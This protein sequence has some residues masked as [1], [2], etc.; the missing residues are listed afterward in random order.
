[1]INV[2]NKMLLAFGIIIVISV[3]SFCISFWGYSSIL[4]A[5]NHIDSNK[6]LEDSINSIKS[7]VFEEQQILA[8][9]I[10][11]HESSKKNFDDLYNSVNT[12]IDKL[13]SGNKKGE[14]VKRLEGKDVKE[15]NTLKEINIKYHELFVNQILTEIE[16]DNKR[17]L[18]TLFTEE[19]K[20]FANVLELEQKLFDTI[21]N[22]VDSGLADC[23]KN[24]QSLKV[25]NAGQVAG[26]QKLN[27]YLEEYRDAY[28]K[29]ENSG[30]DQSSETYYKTLA[31]LLENLGNSL[32]KISAQGNNINSSMTA[33]KAVL[34][35]LRLEDI[36][37]NLLIRANVSKLIFATQSKYYY[38]ADAM[39]AKDEAFDKY[40]NEVET[41]NK[42]I[43]TLS[44]SLYGDEIK[45]IDNIKAAN[46]DMDKSFDPIL[47]EVRRINSNPLI[48]QY[49]NSVELMKQYD[50]STK[51]LEG[52]F[53][54]YL[55]NDVKSSEKIREG[56]IISLVIVTLI[57]LVL[58]MVL[59]LVLSNNILNPIRAMTHLLNKA[60][61]GD[62]TV[63][64][65]LNRNDEI[66]ELGEKVNCILDGQ[67]KMVGQVMSTTKDIS[68]LKQKLSEVFNQSRENI[69]K[70]S[71]GI[72]N[73]VDNIKN[74]VPSSHNSF[75]NMDQ[76]VSG[77]KGVS[78]ATSKV[79][80]DGIKAIEV[81][82]TGEKS[83]EEAEVVIKKVTDTVQQIAGSINELEFSSG[84]IGDITNTITDIASRTN[85]LALNAAIEASRAGQQGKGFAVLADEIRKLAEGSNR[86]AGEI[87]NQ[88]KEIQGKI[89]FAV[90]NM[91]QGVHGVEEGVEKINQV[92]TNINEIIDSMRYVVDS[93]KDTAEIA[94]KQTD[95][96][97]AFVKVVDNITKAASDTVSTSEKLNK[98]VEVQT[99][100]FKE[101]EALS[102]KLDEAS[103]NLCQVLKQVKV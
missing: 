40:K 70:I 4:S 72:K 95:T 64:A 67:Q 87:K 75:K 52:S 47:A 26:I 103:E 60:V 65:Q 56:I 99:G 39:I 50:T 86:A 20:S 17:K 66:G 83:V 89:Q 46:A 85:L 31:E 51:K 23:V 22:R 10:I 53:K 97:E 82:C 41:V 78:E 36:Q 16:Q 7:R 62:L 34:D 74:G 25:L 27:G 100:I 96:T 91:N 44:K 14:Q 69:S 6:E 38:Q 1:M 55:T 63:R 5:V 48:G 33:S 8:G 21:G 19:G 93:V 68:T 57:S 24:L 30:G 58:G 73:V 9:S 90:D 92:K 13:L 81:A 12:D 18:L 32:G 94:Y 37:R 61:D 35:Q 80:N 11:S 79:V 101:M 76:L 77:V 29:A 59:A 2:R 88:I 3:I 71:G 28:K 102:K 43:Q 98:N 49:N 42:H 84:K 54:G 15:L 45:V